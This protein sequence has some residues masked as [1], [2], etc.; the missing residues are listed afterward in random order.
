MGSNSFIFT[1][2]GNRVRLVAPNL[3]MFGQIAE[4]MDVDIWQFHLHRRD[5]SN[6]FRN[7][8][9]DETLAKISE[10]VEN[11]PDPEMS[12]KRILDYIFENY[13]Y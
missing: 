8:I 10:E 13:T 11:T 12:K 9:H 7:K 3:M 5:F 1:G 4:A 2:I 6:W